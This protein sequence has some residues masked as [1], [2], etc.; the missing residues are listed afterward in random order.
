M[1]KSHY[2]NALF[3]V[4][5]NRGAADREG[6]RLCIASCSPSIVTSLAL[7]GMIA[8]KGNIPAQKPNGADLSS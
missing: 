4:I 7:P 6:S 8:I 2:D 3:P 5:P 1:R